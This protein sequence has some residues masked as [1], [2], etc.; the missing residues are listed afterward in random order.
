MKKMTQKEYNE[1]LNST[2]WNKIRFEVLIRDN[3]ICKDCGKTACRV[4]HLNYLNLKDK[5]ILISLCHD[6]HNKRHGLN[7]SQ[8]PLKLGWA[9]DIL[10]S[11]MAENNNLLNCP[12]CNNKFFFIDEYGFFYCNTCIIGGDIKFLAKLI[13]HLKK[14]KE[15]PSILTDNN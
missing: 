10:I 5:S 2:E 11:A 14:K 9:N 12:K 15:Q 7:Y 3:F 4:H 1:F 6:C 13:L 8:N